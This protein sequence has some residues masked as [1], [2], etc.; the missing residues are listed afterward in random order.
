MA[1]T[2]NNKNT[3]QRRPLVW[4]H[5]GASGYAPENTLPAFQKAFQMGADGIELD[6]QM[7]KD[8]EL[9]VC[10]DETIGRTSNGSGWI[11]DKTLAELKA[12][13]FSC[14]QKDFAGVTI[15]TMRE[16]FE[17]LA[18][19]DMIINIELKTGIVFYLGMAKKLLDLTSECGFSDRVIYSS[20]NHYTIKH[21]REI[22]PEAKLGFLYA[23]G[24]IDMPSYAIKH[25]VQA[26]H[27]ALYNIQF[28]GFIE[29]CRQRGLAVNVWTVNEEEHLGLCCKAGVDAII[30][31]YP[32]K[33][34]EII[35]RLI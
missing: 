14:G 13:D 28:P 15:P 8:G 34:F 3:V 22:A 12:L 26:L 7:T 27:P 19:T 11:K 20:F 33:A 31:N 18:P 1:N 4:A 32:D 24:T 21:I 17:L 35:G 10:H 16:V 30:T 2:E 25:G 29:E 23:D 6:V 5:R 9:V